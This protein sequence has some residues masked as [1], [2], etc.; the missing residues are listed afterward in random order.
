MPCFT[1]TVSPGKNNSGD[2]IL[3]YVLNVYDQQK[4]RDMYKDHPLEG[5]AKLRDKSKELQ[6]PVRVSS[7]SHFNSSSTLSHVL[8]ALNEKSLVLSQTANSTLT[9]PSPRNIA[10]QYMNISSRHNT[11][12][13][14]YLQHQHQCV[15][16]RIKPLPTSR[17][18]LI[19]L[20]G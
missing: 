2:R 18:R 6:Y 1:A 7:Q 8:H 10:K 19:S 11:P 20:L 12:S 3:G 13:L 4:F 17:R 15:P 14:I 16:S 5:E 9:I